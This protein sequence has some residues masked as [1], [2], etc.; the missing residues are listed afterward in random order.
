MNYRNIAVAALCAVTLSGAAF[1]A[2]TTTSKGL[3][4][5][6]DYWGKTAVESFYSRQYISGIDG[7]FHPNDDITREGVASIIDKMIGGET[8]ATV[9]FKDVKGRWSEKAVASMVDKQIMKG[10]GDDSFK[11]EKDVTRQE[12]AVIAYNY[13]NYKGAPAETSAVEYKDAKDIAPWAKKA[14][15]M[16]NALGVMKGS[17][18][19]FLPSKNI[20]RGEAVNVL[21]RLQAE[22]VVSKNQG[23]ELQ[24]VVLSDVAKVYGSVKKF[25]DDGNL[26]WNGNTL[27]VT[28]KTAANRNKLEDS[29][30][31]D[32]R[33]AEGSVIVV[34]NKYSFNEY[35]KIQ[36]DALKLYEKTEKAEGTA[37]VDYLNEQV[38]LKVPSVSKETKKALEKAFG[39]KVRTRIV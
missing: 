12:F 28:A 6:N 23:A 4:D 32:S 27:Y 14:V 31:A 29:F 37:A 21:Y 7:K 33:I 22:P 26:Y 36:E 16:L 24:K 1:A 15:D 10:Y 19:L 35:K 13:L 3:T 25:A 38:V 9:D 11:P 2:E 5:I 17:D 18:G 20:T 8:T 34:N 39:A 30:K